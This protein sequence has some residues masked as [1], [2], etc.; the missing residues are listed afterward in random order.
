MFDEEYGPKW[1]ESHHKDVQRWIKD[2]DIKVKTHVTRGIENAAT[3]LV[4]VLKG[5]NFGK[6]VLK[7]A[8]M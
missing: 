8:D 6:A 3:G 2:G 7:L 4:G 1:S 5:E